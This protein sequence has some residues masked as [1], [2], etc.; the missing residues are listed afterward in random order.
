MS[1]TESQ[2]SSAEEE[3]IEVIAPWIELA[4]ISGWI[5]AGDLS[6]FAKWNVHEFFSATSTKTDEAIIGVQK[7]NTITNTWS[8]WI[9]YIDTMSSN[10]HSMAMTK[11]KTMIY[12]HNSQQE[13]IKINIKTK[14]I[15]VNPVREDGA[16]GVALCIDNEFHI[17]GGWN[18]C[19]HKKYNDKLKKF[20]TE[21]EFTAFEASS[22]FDS[23]IIWIDSKQLILIMGGIA[24]T[25]RDEIYLYD[26]KSHKLDKLSV[27][28]PVSMYELC[29]VMTMNEKYVL[30]MAGY[31]STG[32]NGY[33]KQIYVLDMESMVM[34]KSKI[35]IPFAKRT[36]AII[37]G[38]DGDKDIVIN[39]YLREIIMNGEY[40][41]Q[42]IVNV[43]AMFYCV[44]MLHIV[45]D[46]GR[47][48]A[49][50]VDVILD[51][52]TTDF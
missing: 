10:I 18:H 13:V 37:M 23:G 27:T 14:E 4:T 17:I 38:H 31:V 11:D 35:E 19:S 7:Y 21:F 40:V 30:I 15:E 49:L 22:F 12:I 41:V 36:R 24:S 28:L 43:I 8:K 52:C 25:S 6:V 39:G 46:G 20:E 44:E 51:D 42:D 34:M 32:F 9:S 45:Q 29:V 16:N 3:E 48:F 47:H 33:I 2:H 26:P 1:S 5:R 50:N